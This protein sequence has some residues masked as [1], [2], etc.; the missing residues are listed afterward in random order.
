MS[1]KS[2]TKKLPRREFLKTAGVVG[3]ASAAA[4]VATA[5]EAS[6]ETPDNSAN[7]YRETEHVKTYYELARY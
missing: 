6:A 4:A 5:S 1:D 7:G 2:D 3:V